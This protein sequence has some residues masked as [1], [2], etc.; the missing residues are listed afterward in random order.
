MPCTRQYR[1]TGVGKE[2]MYKISV[3]NDCIGCGAC[4]SVCN[5]FELNKAK[6]KHKKGKVEKITCEKEAAD[7]CPV[8]AIKIEKV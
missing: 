1:I 7:T 4:A 5:M 2:K 3:T 6:A 8:Q